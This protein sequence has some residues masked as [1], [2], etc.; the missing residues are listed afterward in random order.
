[1]TDLVFE[2]S[3]SGEVTDLPVYTE[4]T[5]SQTSDPTP[6]P[7]E[8][9]AAEVKPYGPEIMGVALGSF[10][11]FAIGSFVRDIRRG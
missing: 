3:N 8:R 6:S 9:L 2:V 4:A 1:M 5:H 10:A 7:F 11:I